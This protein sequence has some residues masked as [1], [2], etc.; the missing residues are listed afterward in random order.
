[1][2]KLPMRLMTTTRNR[3]GGLILAGLQDSNARFI[4]AT[5]ILSNDWRLLFENQSSKILN[6]PRAATMISLLFLQ[7]PHDAPASCT[8]DEKPVHSRSFSSE[9]AI[10]LKVPIKKT[11][12]VK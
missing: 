8:K 10:V 7:N 9:I 3:V 1:M 6:L 5:K 4:T 12:E 2:L 11:L